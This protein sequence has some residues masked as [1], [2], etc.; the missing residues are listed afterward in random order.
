MMRLSKHRSEDKKDLH[1][2]KTNKTELNFYLS[3]PFSSFRPVFRF[4]LITDVGNQ[5]RAVR[6][7][8][9]APG[10][11]GAS[12]NPDSRRADHGVCGYIHPPSRY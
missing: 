12:R 2:K 10:A 9:S 11:A 1:D 8:Y 4:Y 6:G 5:L 7:A 3:G